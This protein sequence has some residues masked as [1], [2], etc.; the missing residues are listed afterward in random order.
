MTK[1]DTQKAIDEAVA[2]IREDLEKKAAAFRD[3]VNAKMAGEDD[4]FD[5]NTIESLW[6]ESLRSTAEITEELF[7][8][9]G[10]GITEEELLKKKRTGEKVRAGAKE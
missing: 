2:K 8:K 3:G 5:I 10:K 7:S 4:S 6:G 9:L 1:Q